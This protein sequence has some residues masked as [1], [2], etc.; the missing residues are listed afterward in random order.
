MRIEM[1]YVIKR[2]NTFTYQRAIPGAL[3]GKYGKKILRIRL[4]ATSTDDVIAEAAALADQHTAEFNHLLGK[5]PVQKTPALTQ[6]AKEMADTERWSF[7]LED[8]HP[9]NREQTHQY[10]V[11]HT[12]SNLASDGDEVAQQAMR[13]LQANGEPFASDALEIWKRWKGDN[14]NRQAEKH[15]RISVNHFIEV[16]GDKRI[17]EYTR[18]DTQKLVSYLL[19][20]RG[21]K[22]GS[23]S[24]NLNDLSSIFNRCLNFM[25]LIGVHN[26]IFE[27]VELPQLNDSKEREELTEE[28]LDACLQVFRS[29]SSHVVNALAMLLETGCSC[30][31]IVELGLDDIA[32]VGEGTADS[33]IAHIKIREKPWRKLKTKYRTRT[34]PLVGVALEAAK[35]AVK[36]AREQ[37]ETEVLFPQWRRDDG[38]FATESAATAVSKIVKQLT[39]ATKLPSGYWQGGKTVYSLRHS[40]VGRCLRAGSKFSLDLRYQLLGHSMGS[41]Q[42]QHYTHSELPLEEKL[43]AMESIKLVG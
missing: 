14:L 11:E 37:G 22:T 26:N 23:V 43:E 17:T 29:R 1:K 16:C 3:Q 9:D 10:L 32:G 24:R 21:M 39:G 13:I 20:T 33:N 35:N 42:Q 2:G 7:D 30:A 41:I 5:T 38:S 36:T 31:E 8:V 15:A 27:K 19:N 34:I 6:A 28:E 40:Y 12:L 18:R 25:G 4:K